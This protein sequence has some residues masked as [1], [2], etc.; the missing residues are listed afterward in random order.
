M[1]KI[2][3]ISK[4]GVVTHTGLKFVD[5]GESTIITHQLQDGEST[6][7]AD[8]IAAVTEA[9]VPPEFIVALAGVPEEV[10][11]D[12]GYTVREL[13]DLEG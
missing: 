13:A 5:D 3:T 11:I 7:D 2:V 4:D 6:A 8:V 1:A 12:A 9:G 10:I